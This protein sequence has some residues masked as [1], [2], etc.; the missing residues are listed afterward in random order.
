V[1]LRRHH[2]L[3]VDPPIAC[4]AHYRSMAD[5]KFLLDLQGGLPSPLLLS[6]AITS[7]LLS[8]DTDWPHV[9][10]CMC[11]ATL[12]VQREFTWS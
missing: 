12:H 1:A 8:E 10:A 3:T 6:P 9:H 2:A 7:A 11:G 4:A 5:A